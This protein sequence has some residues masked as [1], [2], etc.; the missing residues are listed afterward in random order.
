M[1]K[2]RDNTQIVLI[3]I[4]YHDSMNAFEC[5]YGDNITY[6]EMEQRSYIEFKE[7]MFTN[8]CKDIKFRKHERIGHVLTI[9]AYM[10]KDEI[11]KFKQMIE[12]DTIKLIHNWI[13]S[14]INI[15]TDSEN[16][17]SL[18]KNKKYILDEDNPEEIESGFDNM[19]EEVLE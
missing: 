3:N 16:F 15:I 14:A 17:E 1:K 7:L 2:E 6:Q 4:Q 12:A 19:D 11:L 8:I 13:I 9:K 18:H 10:L 5:A